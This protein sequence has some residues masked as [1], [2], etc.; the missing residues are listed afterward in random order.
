MS[1]ALAI[2]PESQFFPDFEER[3]S[4]RSYRNDGSTFWISSLSRPAMLDDKT[5]ET[6]D[7]DSLAMSH[8]FS[9][10]IEDGVENDFRIAPREVRKFFIDFVN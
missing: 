6:P 8:S 5:A 1:G 9:H 10:G 2:N 7:L 4:L 3:H